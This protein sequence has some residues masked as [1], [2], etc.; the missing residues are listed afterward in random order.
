MGTICSSTDYSKPTGK[1]KLLYRIAITM[2]AA[3]KK[4][5]TRI[6]A[7]KMSQEVRFNINGE[8]FA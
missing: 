5:K 3:K 2:E 6:I 4:K 1:I 7:V 8:Y